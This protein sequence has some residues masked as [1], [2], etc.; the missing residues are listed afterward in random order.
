MQLSFYCEFAPLTRDI[1]ILETQRDG[2]SVGDKKLPVEHTKKMN[3]GRK[4]TKAVNSFRKK[5]PS[6]MFKSVLNTAP[7]IYQ[8]C[9]S[10][11][12]VVENPSNSINNNSEKVISRAENAGKVLK[13]SEKARHFKGV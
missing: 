11:T 12:R 5:A 9:P 1:N 13:I 6:Q 8:V 10:S 4:Q 2:E 7:L 3:I